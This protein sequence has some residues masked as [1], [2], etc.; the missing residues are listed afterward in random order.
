MQRTHL[1]GRAACLAALPLT[2]G[3]LSA[4]DSGG[5]GPGPGPGPGPIVEACEGPPFAGTVFITPG[6]ITPADSSAFTGATSAGRGSRRMFDRRVDGWVTVDAY[7]VDVTFRDGLGTE[8]QVNP[9]F[10]SADAAL[11]EAVRFG[12]VIGRLPRALRAGVETVW[13]HRGTQPFGG[14]NQNLLIHTG[15]ADAYEAGGVLE[16]AFVH[17]AAH[18]SLD[19][20]HADAPGW[21]AAQRADSCFVSTYARDNPTRED[22]AESFLP[23][24][25]LRHR[26]DSLPTDAR[27]AITEAMPGRIAYFEGLP[28]DLYPFGR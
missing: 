22:V 5:A 11:A 26:P 1:L 23:Y 24:L 21:L 12:P 20:A 13:V 19:A 10:G 8:V 25:A 6:L 2:I 16:E 27:A 3:F 14:G 4:C 17:E 15:Q 7:L 28:L 9:E 18:T